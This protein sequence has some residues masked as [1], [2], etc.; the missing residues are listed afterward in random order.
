MRSISDLVSAFLDA[1]TPDPPAARDNSIGS[2]SYDLTD[3]FQDACTRDTSAHTND[4][5]DSWGTSAPFQSVAEASSL[6][7]A[8]SFTTTTFG[9]PFS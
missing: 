7:H 2:S 3:N 9:D 1:I 6:N 4:W 8:S 5:Q